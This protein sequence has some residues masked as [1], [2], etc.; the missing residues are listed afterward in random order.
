VFDKVL[1]FSLTT[2]HKQHRDGGADKDIESTSSKRKC[3]DSIQRL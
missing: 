2:T 1:F 3:D